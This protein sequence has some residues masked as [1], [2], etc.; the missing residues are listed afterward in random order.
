MF[1]SRDA[2]GVPSSILAGLG[3]H[4]LVCCYYLLISK[5]KS[6]GRTVLWRISMAILIVLSISLIISAMSIDFFITPYDSNIMGIVFFF[7]NVFDILVIIGIVTALLYRLRIFYG[8]T[9]FFYAMVVL[10]AISIILKSVAH[11]FGMALMLQFQA[12]IKPGKNKLLG[13]ISTWTAIAS[14][15]EGPFSALTSFFFI[16]ALTDNSET[17]QLREILK[18][19]IGIRLAIVLF[20][21][22]VTIILGIWQANNDNFISHLV[23]YIPNWT[24]PLQMYCYLDLT[25]VS[26]KKLLLQSSNTTSNGSV[27]EH[28]GITKVPM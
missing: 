4:D 5:Y 24:Y 2:Y 7:G 6:A 22:L 10:G 3:L 27:K 23:F 14:C 25:Y 18:K 19:P 17:H 21:N 11:G 13:V 15:F 8:Q 9:R 1:R 26:A 12:G 16:Y 28:N 20:L